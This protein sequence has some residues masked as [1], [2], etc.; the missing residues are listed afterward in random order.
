MRSICLKR[1]SGEG[2][3]MMQCTK[4]GLWQRLVGKEGKRKVGGKQAGVLKRTEA[5][6]EDRP[7][8]KVVGWIMNRW[9]RQITTAKGW[10]RTWV[11]IF[12]T[13]VV[14]NSVGQA[15]RH[16]KMR[17]MDRR[18]IQKQKLRSFSTGSLTRTSLKCLHSV[19]EH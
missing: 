7:T 5:S 14:V 16:Y 13:E 11:E 17:I 12:A 6:E 10:K 9:K 18:Y 19:P 15:A 2:R 3:Y 8:M 4:E 1:D